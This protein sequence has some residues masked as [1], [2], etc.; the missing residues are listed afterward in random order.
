MAEKKLKPS[1]RDKKRYLKLEGSPSKKDI[2]KAILEF[3]GILGYAKAAPEFPRKGVVAVN[4][5]EVDKIRAALL[6]SG[7]IRVKKVSGSIKNVK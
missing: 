2:E 1:M 6:L 3:V 7:N 4:R 5:K